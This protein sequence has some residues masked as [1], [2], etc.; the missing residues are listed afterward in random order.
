MIR[1]LHIFLVSMGLAACSLFGQ[2]DLFVSSH[3]KSPSEVLAFWGGQLVQLRIL[4]NQ[5]LETPSIRVLSQALVAPVELADVEFQ[6]IQLE[7]GLYQ[8]D[9]QFRCPEAR[10]QLRYM[11][12]FSGVEG[13]V[14]LDA[15]PSWLR[16]QTVRQAAEFSIS[17]MPQH[18]GAESFFDA[19][20]VDLAQEKETSLQ[21]QHSES[22]L[23]IQKSERKFI[24]KTNCD[25]FSLEDPR[26]VLR[27]AEVLETIRE[28]N[29]E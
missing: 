20:G 18:S 6:S 5:E 2:T 19:L 27:F 3:Y 12:R 16:T 8:H 24:W 10:A 7:D 15:Y 14:L 4:S 23:L 9:F 25:A 26:T 11:M 29:K 22:E 28:F 13:A 21:I 1:V 17:V